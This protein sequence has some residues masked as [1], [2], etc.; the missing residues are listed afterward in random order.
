MLAPFGKINEQFFDLEPLRRPLD[1]LISFN[2][3][4]VEHRYPLARLPGHL[5]TL[6]VK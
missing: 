2:H 4:R 5:T 3:T 1:P 6:V